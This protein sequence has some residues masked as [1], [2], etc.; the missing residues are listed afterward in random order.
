MEKY[1]DILIYTISAIS[2]IYL[3]YVA[4]LVSL[5]VLSLIIKKRKLRNAMLIFLACTIVVYAIL[6]VPRFIDLHS[7]SFIKVENATIERDDYYNFSTDN[8]FFGHG[9]IFQVDGKTIEVS[10]TDLF[11]FPPTDE[12]EEFYGDIVYAKRSHQ[13]IAM[14]NY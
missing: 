14:E 3:V 7:N 11:E 12:L 10:G 8:L 6:V 1:R 2:K 5:L 13:L 9:N 4:V